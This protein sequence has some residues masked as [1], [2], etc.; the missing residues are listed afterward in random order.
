MLPATWLPSPRVPMSFPTQDEGLALE[1]MAL[2]IRGGV[3]DGYPTI[4]NRMTVAVDTSESPK[5]PT[6]GFELPPPKAF[7]DE[8]ARL[9]GSCDLAYRLT[10]HDSKPPFGR[11]DPSGSTTSPARRRGMLKRLALLSRAHAARCLS[12][13][14]VFTPRQRVRRAR[15]RSDRSARCECG[16]RPCLV[17]DKGRRELRRPRY[18]WNTS[19]V[20]S[21]DDL[22]NKLCAFRSTWHATDEEFD[23]LVCLR[24]DFMIKTFRGV[25][26]LRR[27]VRK[28]LDAKAQSGACPLVDMPRDAMWLVAQHLANQSIVPLRQTCS[29]L[30]DN[31]ELKSRMPKFRAREVVGCFPHHRR[32]GRDRADVA[33]D[34][35]AARNVLVKHKAVRLFVDL[36]RELRRPVP[37]KH[38]RRYHSE[39][40][41]TE[42]D[43]SEDDYEDAPEAKRRRGKHPEPPVEMRPQHAHWVAVHKKTRMAWEREDGPEEPY[44][45]DTTNERLHF[46]RF[47]DMSTPLRMKATLVF[48]DTLEPVNG[49][50][51]ESGVL[52]APKLSDQGWFSPSTQ[53]ETPMP[54]HL[55]LYVTALSSAHC[56]RLFRF[57]LSVEATLNDRPRST[58]LDTRTFSVCVFTNPFEVVSR[59]SVAL[60]PSHA[61]PTSTRRCPPRRL[62][63]P[64]SM[65]AA[66]S[67]VTSLDHWNRLCGSLTANCAEASPVLLQCGSKTC[68]LSRH[69]RGAVRALERVH[70]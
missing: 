37:L 61:A 50:V 64:F 55:R 59:F 26:L 18:A 30:R 24:H 23:T 6:G 25:E 21:M 13:S 62:A 67:P 60:R 19:T 11:F 5:P 63:L 10:A 36:V 31:A 22:R 65:H 4:T 29:A 45:K 12:S 8:V 48:A 42:R 43:F 66:P 16:L 20:E 28:H 2:S 35:A 53:W 56:N 38:K 51:E 40:G 7:R 33:C 32:A 39:F 47:F 41:R 27:A 52:P 3:P 54:V 58:P 68:P 57:K 1:I 34:S 15:Q 17:V 49:E 14:A 44:D 70:V 46:G 69:R 9:V